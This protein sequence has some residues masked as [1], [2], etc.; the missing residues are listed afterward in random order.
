M[1]AWGLKVLELLRAEN[2]KPAWLANQTKISRSTIGNWLNS[3]HRI[4]PEPD[5]VAKVAKAFGLETRDLAPYAG[6]PIVDSLNSEHREARKAAPI[7]APR[8]A[9]MGDLLEE[10]SA[11]DQDTVISMVEAFVTARRK[12]F[13]E[14]Q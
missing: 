7:L 11:R 10:L 2:Q 12:P 5:N 14:H 6:Y 9:R 4:R 1:N 3:Q 13:P 8:I